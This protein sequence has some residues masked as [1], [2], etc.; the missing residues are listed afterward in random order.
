MSF[1]LFQVFLFRSGR[2]WFVGKKKQEK[3]KTKTSDRYIFLPRESGTVLTFLLCLVFVWCFFPA[4][5]QCDCYA[6]ATLMAIN[7]I[8]FNVILCFHMRFSG[9]LAR[10]RFKKRTFFFLSILKNENK[11]KNLSFSFSFSWLRF[12]I[13]WF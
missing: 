4:V 12:Y 13:L 5:F 11:N 3:K 9:S 8:E 6:N 7:I 2:V 1:V 10:R